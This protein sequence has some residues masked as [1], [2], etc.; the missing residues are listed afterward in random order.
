MNNPY[1]PSFEGELRVADAAIRRSAAYTPTSAERRLNHIGTL[2]VIA[3][4][5]HRLPFAEPSLGDKISTVT[6]GQ[7]AAAAQS[8][9]ADSTL[10]L[11][12]QEVENFARTSKALMDVL[13]E[14]GKIHPFIAGQRIVLRTTAISNFHSRR[15]R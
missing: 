7:A 9:V 10:S 2:S 15:R 8:D 14:V 3:C 13:D 1:R 12:K 6:G 5:S 11:V 4:K